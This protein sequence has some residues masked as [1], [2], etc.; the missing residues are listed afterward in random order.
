[1]VSS[2]RELGAAHDSYDNAL[3]EAWVATFKSELLDGGRFSVT[4]R[5]AGVVFP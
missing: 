3:A 4:T 5:Q 2:C 1:M